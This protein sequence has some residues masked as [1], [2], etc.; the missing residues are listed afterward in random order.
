VVGGVRRPYCVVVWVVTIALFV[1]VTRHN[2]LDANLR[3]S[4]GGRAITATMRDWHA[5][6]LTAWYLAIAGLI[7]Q[8]FW[9][10]WSDLA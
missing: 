1:Y 3:S 7:L 9:W 6:I 5:V 8:H 2:V 10:Y 4:P